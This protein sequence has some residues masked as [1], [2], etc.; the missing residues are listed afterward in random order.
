M[1]PFKTRVK[2]L[3]FALLVAVAALFSSCDSCKHMP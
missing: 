3:L 2:I 1:P